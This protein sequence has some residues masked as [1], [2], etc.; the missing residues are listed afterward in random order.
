[1]LNLIKE[2]TRKGSYFDTSIYR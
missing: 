2:E 1:M